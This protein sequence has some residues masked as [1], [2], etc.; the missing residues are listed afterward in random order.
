M[1]EFEPE[2][3]LDVDVDGEEGA[4]ERK[5]GDECDDAS[6]ADGECEEIL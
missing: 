1:A 3:G 5:K 6:S 2:P 4:R